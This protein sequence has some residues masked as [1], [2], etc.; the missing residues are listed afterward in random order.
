ML[1][2][3]HGNA[4]SYMRLR[5]S[6]GVID[7]SSISPGL[8]VVLFATLVTTPVFAAN[9]TWTG[10][11]GATWSTSATNWSNLSGTPWD[12]TNGGTNAAIFTTA[13]FS[14]TVSGTVW[15]NA[16]T[17]NESGTVSGGTI[18]L[19]GST[20]TITATSGKI[21]TIGSTLAGSTGFTKS[22]A[23]TL[24]LAGSNAYSGTTTLSAGTL[25]LGHASA[26]GTSILTT[27]GTLA[28][29]TPLTGVNKVANN[30]TVSSFTIG[31]SNAIDLSG[32]FTAS[33]SGQ[34]VTINNSGP[35]T[36][37]GPIWIL[38]GT[39]AGSFTFSGT[40]NFTISGP[41]GRD[42][43]GQAA[44]TLGNLNYAGSGVM[45]LSGSNAFGGAF[46]ISN[47]GAASFSNATALG[48][49]NSTLW[50][51]TNSTA[52]SFI[53]TGAGESIGKSV[54]VGQTAGQT[55]MT[56]ILDQS[57]SGLLSYAG[58]TTSATT[59]GVPVAT[60]TLVLQ[61]STSGTGQI[62]GAVGQG[63]GATL[64][65]VKQGSGIWL[66][67]GANTYSGSTLITGGRL[68][69]TAGNINSSSGITVNGS[70]AELRYNSA[71]ALTKALT[72]TQGTLSGTG[73]INTAVSVGSNSIL[74]P[75][76][77]PGSQS[78]T[79]GLVFA[80]GGQ[81]TWEI[82]NWAG[83]P[84]TGYDQLVVSGSALNITA[85]SGSTFKIAITGLNASNASGV[86]PGFSGTAGTSFT[87]ATSSAGITGFD[88][89]EFTLDASGFTTN[90]PLPTNAG[91][92]VSQSGNN[93]L[94]NYAPSATYNL[95]AAA[96]A[97]A[98]RVGGTSWITA[99]VTSSTAGVTN[100]DSVA[101]SGLGLSGGLGSLSSTSGTL[102]G[103]LTGSGSTAFTTLSSG[104]YAFTPSVTS[105]TN[106]NIGTNANAGST[107][108][109]SVTVWNPAAANAISGTLSLGTVLKGATLSQAL[110]I[111]NTAPSN[112]FSEKLDVGFGT[113]SG[114]TTNSGSISLLNPQATN[115]SSMIV[116]FSTATAGAM[117]GSAQVNFWTN[118]QGTSG[119]ASL[120]LASQ[121]V[122]LTG[123]VLDPA[124]ASFAS[125]TTATTSL[126]LDFGDVNQNASVSPLG[127]SLYNLMQTN[128]FTADLALL[129]IVSST[130]NTNAI[131]TTLPSEFYNLAAGN[132]SAYS[133]SLS[134]ATL[135]AFQNVYTL[136]F[137]SAN[138]G[139]A[140]GADTTQ[141][142]TLTVQGV[143]V[144]PEPA[145]LA[146]IGVTLVAIGQFISKHRKR[147]GCKMN[148][149]AVHTEKL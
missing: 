85:T 107:T 49:N 47:G 3:R 32:T 108:G 127:F 64:A 59:S 73:T 57:G 120:P 123:T 51:G 21:A 138:N 121:T 75:G 66:L 27:G 117:A 147:N 100:P 77:S 30:L 65:I 39:A 55:G 7:R 34:T 33:A 114:V 44:A 143:I 144:V 149:V 110:I 48:N 6:C 145:S 63:A 103:G 37:S 87:I 102:A 111:Q 112:G 46:G 43:A 116:G 8:F 92:W 76:N 79:Q 101:F 45:T 41:I 82:N 94:L 42:S 18:T 131:T 84:G 148:E 16:I 58:I 22:G 17:L 62:T 124:M 1:A 99:A 60:G 25:L 130:G 129:N 13:N 40:S 70:G 12:V 126:L 56:G 142:L 52:G 38:S 141:N 5:S 50:L 31:G 61:G 14:P 133:A 11:A 91:F 118:G 20:P 74:S 98:I 35:T 115:A 19:A 9:G 136:Q 71:T 53:Y 125:G 135:G 106:V 97:T 4:G 90:N 109:V 81:Y 96:S 104:S 29:T 119:L 28:A 72:L 146:L 23:G 89:S 10:G 24:V 54:R 78:F 122:S 137:K 86:V 105:A 140:F 134:T 128:G 95:S 139:T 69:I 36:F 15:L 93:L 113:L 2:G 68:T 88:K 83:S 26:L 132:S 80:P 67:S